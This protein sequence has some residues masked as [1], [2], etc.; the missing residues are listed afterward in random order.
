MQPATLRP[1]SFVLAATDHGSMILNRNDYRMVGPDNGFG[2]G[3]QLLTGSSFDAPEIRGAL[4][5]LS[6]RRRDFGDGVV[7]L[8]C[9]ANIGVHTIEWARAMNGWGRVMAFEPQERIFYALAGNIA[10]NNCR[11][12][13][14]THAALGAKSGVLKI[15]DLDYDAPASFGSLELQGRPGGPEFI[16][17][18]IDY[19]RLSKEVRLVAID[20]LKL[21]RLDFVK[22]D[23]EGMELEV[24][25]GAAVSI[26]RHRPIM[27]IETL[28]SGAEPIVAFLA[29]LGY[30]SWPWGIN[31]IAVHWSDP[32]AGRISSKQP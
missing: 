18:K 16:G 25:R 6:S 7:A 14:A 17:Q 29:P 11:N 19:E 10:I 15:P 13:S 26:G 32:T 28:K 27:I 9:G 5:L 12:A 4:E 8:D 30:R 2:V 31:L 22:I 1:I 24:L 20:D 21:E 23:V 3:H